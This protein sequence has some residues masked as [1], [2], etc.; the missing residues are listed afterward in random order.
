[1]Y[2]I[3]FIHNVFMRKKKSNVKEL[4]IQ[5]FSSQMFYWM[6]LIYEAHFRAQRKNVE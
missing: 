4:F 2:P 6:P 1:M 5:P 3:D